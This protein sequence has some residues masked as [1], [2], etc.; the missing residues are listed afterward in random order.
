MNMKSVL[1]NKFVKDV[2]VH[3][4]DPTI[5]DH[6]RKQILVDDEPELLDILDTAGTLYSKYTVFGSYLCVIPNRETFQILDT[7]K[8]NKSD[9]NEHHIII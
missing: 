9:I 1:I 7:F 2:F 3:D 5:Q 6:A 8:T 4:Y